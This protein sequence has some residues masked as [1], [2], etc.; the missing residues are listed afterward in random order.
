M[1]TFAIFMGGVLLFIFRAFFF[2]PQPFYPPPSRR[3]STVQTSNPSKN[4]TSSSPSSTSVSSI[5]SKSLKNPFEVMGHS[6]HIITTAAKCIDFIRQMRDHCRNFPVIGLDC[7][8]V[9]F[10][11]TR[12]K[13]ALLQLASAS[14]LCLLIRLFQ[15][16]AFPRELRD[17]LGDPRI[18][19][20]GVEVFYDGQKLLQDYGLDV[21]GTVDLRHLAKQLRVPGKFGLGGLA[22]TVL[23]VR[24]DKDWQIS[25]SD[26][27]RTELSHVQ[28]EYAAKDAIVALKL[29]QH[30]NRDIHM[31]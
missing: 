22:E 9:S 13:V 1:I 27:Q 3:S 26:W 20:V 11:G 5:P 18:F 19:K 28:R 30:F 16:D 14:G 6:V 8:W 21:K 15:M 12:Q 2:Q 23:G 29:F 10:Y 31:R 4:S 24:L 17:L 25:A 7:E